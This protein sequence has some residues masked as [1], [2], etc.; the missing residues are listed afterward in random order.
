MKLNFTIWVAQCLAA[1]SGALTS[2]AWGLHVLRMFVWVLSRYSSFLP[3]SKNMQ[4]SLN[5]M[6]E[7]CH[8][9]D[10]ILQDPNA[11]CRDTGEW[12]Q[13]PGII[14][15]P[16]RKVKETNW[17][18]HRHRVGA[19]ADSRRETQWVARKDFQNKR[20]ETVTNPG[21]TFR[22]VCVFFLFICVPVIDCDLP[23]LSPALAV[24]QVG[25]TPASC[26]P[27]TN[28]QYIRQNLS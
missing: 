16:H 12:K 27:S 21:N 1:P 28:E 3:Q 5:A 23:K 22:S 9:W 4:A 6:F 18:Q 7:Y 26:D 2:R 13:E 11:E 17:Q 25:L 19:G 24:C 20:G 14:G 10:Q 8:H 15:E